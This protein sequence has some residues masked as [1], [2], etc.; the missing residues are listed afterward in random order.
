MNRFKKEEARKNLEAC[1]GLSDIEINQLKH[2]EA[3]EA[4][5]NQLA[6]SIHIERFP[7]EYDF[8]FDSVADANSRKRGVNPMSN[9]YIAK[10]AT[11]RQEQNVSPLSSSGQPLSSDTW[12]IA[13]MEAEARF[14]ADNQ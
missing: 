2:N 12:K 7:E 10:I 14:R 6:R 4:K 11:K 1:V 13:Y 8:M 9:D 5:I 3:I